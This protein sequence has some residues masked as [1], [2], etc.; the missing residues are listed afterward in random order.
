MQCLDDQDDGELNA[1][2]LLPH[3]DHMSQHTL[4][5]G[6]AGQGRQAGSRQVSQGVGWRAGLLPSFV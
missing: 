4:S 6:A 2:A 5:G 3:I 1:I